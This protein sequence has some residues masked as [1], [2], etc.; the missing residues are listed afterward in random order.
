M[1]EGGT[2]SPSLRCLRA[3]T[4]QSSPSK[5]SLEEALTGRQERQSHQF[6]YQVGAWK[7]RQKLRLLSTH[8]KQMLGQGFAHILSVRAEVPLLA[9]LLTSC[10]PWNKLLNCP[11]LFPHQYRKNQISV[12]HTQGLA[13]CL[14]CSQPSAIVATITFSTTLGYRRHCH[15]TEEEVQAQK[16]QFTCP[17]HTANEGQS[18]DSNPVDSRGF[19]NYAKLWP[20]TTRSRVLQRRGRCGVPGKALK[21]ESGVLVPSQ[22]SATQQLC[23]LQ[24]WI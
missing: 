18:G 14:T 23:D 5:V 1:S 15:F 16:R 7:G 24:E 6:C 10:V 22:G 8:Y 17:S 20:H 19:F 21:E 11:S 3:L 2:G 4:H 13:Q 9:S 12:M